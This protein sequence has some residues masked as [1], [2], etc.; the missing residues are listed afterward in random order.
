MDFTSANIN[1]S[2]Q[3]IDINLS[4]WFTNRMSTLTAHERK[5][6]GTKFPLTLSGLIDWKF[7]HSEYP[8]RFPGELGPTE[9]LSMYSDPLEGAAN[10]VI[11]RAFV[12][13][14]TIIGITKHRTATKNGIKQLQTEQY[15]LVPGEGLIN[16]T[17]GKECGAIKQAIL[18]THLLRLHSV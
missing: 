14:R 4:L 11:T 8:S 3:K 16:T 18:Y 17:L 15:E 10:M 2:F 7:D 13:D 5:V 6:G 9:S 12:E 1:N